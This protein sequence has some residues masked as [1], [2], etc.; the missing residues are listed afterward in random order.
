MELQCDIC[1]MQFDL[2]LHRPKNLPCGHTIC[3]ECVQNPALGRKCPL[4]R[5][6]LNGDPADL[7]DSIALIRLIENAG[8][9]PLKKPRTEGAEVQRLRRGVEAGRKVVELLQLVVPKAVEA[10]N[11]QLDSS[12]AQLRQVEEA[13]ELQVQRGR[14]AAGVEGGDPVA[15]QL[16]LAGKLED[17]LRLLTANECSVVAVEADGATWRACSQLGGF[18]DML[19]PLLLQLRADDQLE[20]VDVAP[21]PATP[22]VYVGPPTTTVLQTTKDDFKNGHLN[23]TDLF[24]DSL[25]W[26][27]VRCLISSYAGGLE[28]LLRIVAP[29]LEELQ[30]GGVFG[31]PVEHRHRAQPSAMVEVMEMASLKR[32]RVRCDREVNGVFPDL[33]LQ[34]EELAIQHPRENQ[35]RCLERMSR[36]HSLAVH[37]YLGPNMNFAP[38]QHGALRWLGVCLNQ[39]HKATMMSLIHAYASSVEEIQVVCSVNEK[40]KKGFYYPGLGEDLAG[41]HALRRLVLERPRDDP[42]TN[43][44]AGCLLQCRT[45]KSFLPSHVQV[46]CYTCYMPVL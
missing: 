44:V 38:S 11:R 18:S 24:R 8:A 22:G 31:T 33:P 36:L 46:I 5:N 35:L 12:V 32:L 23:F 20:K 4:C 6:D 9:P 3:N 42:C 10:L 14:G 40:V 26:R 39:P 16:Q 28:E 45:F 29:H 15:E 17:N 7:P 1:F 21:F 34:L 13:L 19:R 43:Q 2:H 27:N 41:L 25:R 30:I 37:D